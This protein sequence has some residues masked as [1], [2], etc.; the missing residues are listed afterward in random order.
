MQLSRA[1][2]PFRCTGP[3]SPQSSCD[4]CIARELV[5][6]TRNRPRPPR[7]SLG[8]LRVA[9]VSRR[10]NAWREVDTS[11]GPMCHGVAQQGEPCGIT[12]EDRWVPDDNEQGLH[13]AK[14]RTSTA[15]Q[16]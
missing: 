3:S 4:S 11:V 15:V 14:R 9:A 2:D 10:S 8:L 13:A 16:G 6:S 1:A 12:S 7:P 5:Q